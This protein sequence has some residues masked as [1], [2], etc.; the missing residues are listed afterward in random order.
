MAPGQANLRAICAGLLGRGPDD[1]LVVQLA[2]VVQYLNQDGAIT[3]HA[4]WDV[5]RVLQHA[6]RVSDRLAP[7]PADPIPPAVVLEVAFAACV[8]PRRV[9][10]KE[11]A[12]RVKRFLIVY[13]EP[14]LWD[15]D[16]IVKLLRVAGRLPAGIPDER[17]ME[18]L[19]D[20]T[21]TSPG[22]A[23]YHERVTGAALYFATLTDEAIRGQPGGRGPRFGVLRDWEDDCEF[24]RFFRSADLLHPPSSRYPDQRDDN[25]S[26][27]FDEVRPRFMLE[28]A[29]KPD[30]AREAV[31]MEAVVWGRRPMIA[32]PELYRDL[33]DDFWLKQ[34]QL[35][36]SG[37]PYYGFD[38]HFPR[39]WRACAVNFRNE[40]IK[41]CQRRQELGVQGPGPRE[42][43]GGQEPRRDVFAGQDIKPEMLRVMRE[44]WR[45][46]RTTFYV[47]RP[48]DPAVE[49][50]NLRRVLDELWAYHLEKD[51]LSTGHHETIRELLDR[52]RDLVDEVG[53]VKEARANLLVRRIKGRFR[54]YNLGRLYGK[55]NSEIRENLT[56]WDAG[57]EPA[58]MAVASLGRII[59]CDETL[60]WAFLAHVF[61]RAKIQVQHP[62][63]WD[64]LRCVTE[65]QEWAKDPLLADAIEAG[66]RAGRKPNPLV[67]SS[68]RS[69]YPGASMAEAIDRL[70]SELWLGLR[71]GQFGGS[72][73][74]VMGLVR[75]AVDECGR[76]VYEHIR[77]ILSMGGYP[78]D[79]AGREWIT[80]VWYLLFV[81]DY[82]NRGPSHADTQAVFDRLKIDEEDKVAVRHMLRM[83]REH[84]A[85]RN[86]EARREG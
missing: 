45:L 56:K 86:R 55:K 57:L 47:L 39:W 54:A 60:L 18:C 66:E 49:N 83:M 52:I 67:A 10:N 9:T 46:V 1:A 53:G 75:G 29:D 76:S 3:I 17:V 16:Q 71:L 42:G 27:L 44:G 81:E 41:I 33:L 61:L 2:R 7:D 70:L 37:F 51:I 69:R 25:D 38:A 36:N 80:P 5:V 35:L 8:F 77:N 12:P 20:L 13:Q 40:V 79:G 48:R 23:D 68:L 24:V 63:P 50:E 14:R 28:F 4:P 30:L 22:D 21:A 31:D 84:C 15:A 43:G 19:G 74:W 59:G 82:P 85:A 34:N 32:P 73:E 62:D 26:P 65:V 78:V 6:G 72:V 64:L 58:Q 11:L